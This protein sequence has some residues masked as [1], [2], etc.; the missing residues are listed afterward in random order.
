MLLAWPAPG[1]AQIVGVKEVGHL[2]LKGTL[3]IHI[4]RQI[5]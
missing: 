5:P 4:I 1:N 3:G 2:L